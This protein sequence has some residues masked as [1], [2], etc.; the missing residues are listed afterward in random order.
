MSEPLFNIA[1][2]PQRFYSYVLN[3]LSEIEAR[4]QAILVYL[5]RHC[6]EHHNTE[7]E[8][9]IKNVTLLQN[10]L[11]DRII[12]DAINTVEIRKSP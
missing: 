12:A 11:I 1:V 10:E 8:S 3:K 4:Q 2:D 7:T 5:A 6:S 9:V